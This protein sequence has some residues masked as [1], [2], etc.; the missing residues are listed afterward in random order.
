[1]INISEDLRQNLEHHGLIFET[2]DF[3]YVVQYTDGGIKTK[4]SKNYQECTQSIK[5]CGIDPYDIW[6]YSCGFSSYLTLEDIERKVNSLV[7]YFN[8]SNYHSLKNNCQY[9]VKDLLE[10]IN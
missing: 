5:D 9:F 10:K 1:M 2:D 3:Y 8:E 7:P 6:E 4:R